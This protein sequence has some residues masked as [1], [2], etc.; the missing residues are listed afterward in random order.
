MLKLRSKSLCMKCDQVDGPGYG[1]LCYA[2]NMPL[3]MVGR[4]RKCKHFSDIYIWE[5][6]S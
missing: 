3:Y 6:G 1:D 4:K 2:Y 5:I